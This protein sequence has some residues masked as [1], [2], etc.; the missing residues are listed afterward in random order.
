MIILYYNMLN[1]RVSW[2]YKYPCGNISKALLQK[3]KREDEIL[4]TDHNLLISSL[5]SDVINV[6]NQ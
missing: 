4:K 5:Y 1:Y 2:N 6:F 3:L